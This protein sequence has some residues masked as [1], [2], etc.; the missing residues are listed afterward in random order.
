MY[1]NLKNDLIEVIT[2][3]LAPIQNEY[4]II[5]KDK[6]YLNKILKKGSDLC[7]LKARK[8]LSKVYKKIGLI[9]K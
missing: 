4:K 7:S 6:T 1:S 3:S 8:T 2:N 5:N 9:K